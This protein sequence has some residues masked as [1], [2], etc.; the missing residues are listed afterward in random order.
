MTAIRLEFSTYILSKCLNNKN[1][2][3]VPF[4]KNYK[5]AKDQSH[6]HHRAADVPNIKTI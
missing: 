1:G 3:P 5:N 6:I 2:Y 4:K